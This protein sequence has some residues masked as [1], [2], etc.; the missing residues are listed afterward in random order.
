MKTILITTTLLILAAAAGCTQYSNRPPAS[1]YH[2]DGDSHGGDPYA[3]PKNS[4][5]RDGAWGHSH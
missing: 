5:R 4:N 1:G 2:G 3:R